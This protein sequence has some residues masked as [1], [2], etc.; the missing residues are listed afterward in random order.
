MKKDKTVSTKLWKVEFNTET[1]SL[2]EMC[3]HRCP[4]QAL[5]IRRKGSQEEILFDYGL[6]NGCAGDTYCQ[7]HCPERAVTV[8][9]IPADEAPPEP[10][11][12]ITGQLATCQ[13]YKR[14]LDGD[15]GLNTGGMGTYSPSAFLDAPMRKEIVDTIVRPT[16]EG[17]ARDE[18]PYHGVLYVGVML[19][20]RGPKVL[21]RSPLLSAS[22]ASDENA[23]V[24][25]EIVGVGSSAE[26]ARAPST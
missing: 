5:T 26:A 7:E 2:C 9:R 3:V 16:I 13:D 17:M 14:A 4:T 18:R 22:A 20:D 25:V 21:S 19:T 24:T 10:V 6:C 8:S 12:L 1:C 15:E 23:V 11:V